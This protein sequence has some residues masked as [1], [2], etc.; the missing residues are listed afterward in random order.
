MAAYCLNH[1][2]H[3]LIHDCQIE[4]LK[5]F[6]IADVQGGLLA[7]SEISV[8]YRENVDDLE[9]REQLLREVGIIWQPW[10]H[11]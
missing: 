1:R 5:S 6:D 8:A 4:L 7:L 2:R 10:I 3:V 11:R 9:L